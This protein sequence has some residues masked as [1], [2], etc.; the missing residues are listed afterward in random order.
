MPKPY[1]MKNGEYQ[2]TDEWTFTSSDG[3][4]EMTFKPIIDR[5]SPLD[6]KFMC[7]IPHQVFGLMSGTAILDDSTEIKIENRLVFAERVHNKW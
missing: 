5:Q 4:F 1:P 3:R 6:I 7:M 2:Y